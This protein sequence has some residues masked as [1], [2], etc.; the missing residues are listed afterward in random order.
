MFTFKTTEKGTMF[1]Q[2]GV[3]LGCA[4][5]LLAVPTILLNWKTAFYRWERKC[6][7]PTAEMEMSFVADYGM[8]YQMMPGLM[9]N[10][11]SNENIVAHG[12]LEKIERHER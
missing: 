1:Y 10:Q 4:L 5:S 7:K 6:V 9:Y 8:E 12:Q 2:D 11:N 3:F